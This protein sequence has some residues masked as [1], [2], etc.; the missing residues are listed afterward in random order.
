MLCSVIDDVI[1][2]N[3]HGVVGRGFSAGGVTGNRGL[4]EIN[5]T[6]ACNF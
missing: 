5:E 2:A 4:P 3:L 6:A 1:T